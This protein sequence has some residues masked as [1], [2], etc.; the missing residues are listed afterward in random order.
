MK[1]KK[2][3]FLSLKQGACQ[4]AATVTGSFSSQDMHRMK[5]LRMRGSKSTSLKDLMGLCSML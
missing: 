5:W 3:E 4:S 1:I 2:K